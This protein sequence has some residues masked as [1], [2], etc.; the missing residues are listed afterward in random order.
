MGCEARTRA[1]KGG[2]RAFGP[3][4]WRTDLPSAGMGISLGR[5]RFAG[6]EQALWCDVLSLRSLDPVN[7]DLKG[8]DIS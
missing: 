4:T 6:A 1:V 2:C 8:V 5:V 3:S 7:T